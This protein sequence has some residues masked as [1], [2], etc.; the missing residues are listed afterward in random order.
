[1]KSSSVTHN[2]LSA[3]SWEED[4]SY[5]R[6]SPGRAELDSALSKLSELLDNDVYTEVM[7][8]LKSEQE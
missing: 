5:S 3:N 6:S 4:L 1:M 8:D 7:Q 2:T